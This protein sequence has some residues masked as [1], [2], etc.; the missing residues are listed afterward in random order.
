[1]FDSFFR[2][3]LRKILKL[4]NTHNWNKVHIYI[5]TIHVN[6]EK[7][8][9]QMNTKYNAQHVYAMFIVERPN[10]DISS[11]SPLRIRAPLSQKLITPRQ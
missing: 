10:N 3:S 8:K 6:R 9:G 1:M 2:A 4:L 7:W 11:N 5:I